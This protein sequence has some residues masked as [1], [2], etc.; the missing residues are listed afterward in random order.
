MPLEKNVYC[1]CIYPHKPIKNIQPNERR[2]GNCLCIFKEEQGNK[3]QTTPKTKW[4]RNLP[5]QLY[6]ANTTGKAIRAEQ[7]SEKSFSTGTNR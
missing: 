6:R 3:N 4:R 2:L 1:N 7:Q 5:T